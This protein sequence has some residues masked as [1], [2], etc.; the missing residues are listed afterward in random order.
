MV[1]PAFL[2][3]FSCDKQLLNYPLIV[4]VLVVLVIHLPQPRK[5]LD[6]FS[7]F[8][9]MLLFIHYNNR[10]QSGVL[11]H[12]LFLCVFRVLGGT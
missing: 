9:D 8:L 7:S 2:L 6:E 10:M 3:P 11:F 5:L 12:K 4:L 1:L